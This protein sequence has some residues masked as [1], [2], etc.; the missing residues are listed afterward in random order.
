MIQILRLIQMKTMF[1]DG[2]DS[3]CDGASDFDQDGD[4]ED[5]ADYGGTDCDDIN[6]EESL[7]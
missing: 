5:S 6:E 1:G 3:D 4:G 2:I 7:R